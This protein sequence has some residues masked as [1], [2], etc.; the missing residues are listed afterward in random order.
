MMALMAGTRGRFENSVS[1]GEEAVE[2]APNDV[3][4]MATCAYEYNRADNPE[5][6]L[7]LARQPAFP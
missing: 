1:L 3:I 7:R 6:G 5:A 4:T 2:K